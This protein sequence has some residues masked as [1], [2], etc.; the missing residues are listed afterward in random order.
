MQ[1]T[2]KSLS[3]V[4]WNINGIRSRVFNNNI[5]SKMPKNKTFLPLQNSSMYN[6][7]N[8]TKPDIICLQETRCDESI[9]KLAVIP[10]YYSYFNSS[11]LIDARGPN[12]YSGTALYTKI[13]P[14]KIE[15][16]VPGYN[17]QEG[18]IIIAY[19]DDFII[20]NVYAPNSGTN[21]DN[22]IVFQEALYDF[23]NSLNCRIIFCGDFNIAI[24]THFDKKSTK[25]VPGT[26]KHELDYHRRLLEI[27][28]IDSISL[29]D[30]II[31]TW[32][33]QRS[34][35]IKD[36]DTN[37]ETNILRHQNKGWRIDYIFTK[38]FEDSISKVL[39]H[40]GEEY[41]PHASDHAPVYAIIKY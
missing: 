35:R 11:K 7:I 41:C 29:N 27:N 20:I 28:F 36:A 31:Y 16:N 34:K 5:G 22:K 21:Y 15:Y 19:Y 32:W 1:S 3:V 6:L 26:Y 12:R 13:I 2:N 4:T 38:N 37:K 8:E 9:G 33:D 24:D 17:D 10:E 14:N 18:R 23:V 39:K 40:I 25:P 30:N